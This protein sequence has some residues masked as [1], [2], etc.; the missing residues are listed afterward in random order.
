MLNP[1]QS[2]NQFSSAEKVFLQTFADL[3]V[4]WGDVFFVGSDLQVHRLAAGTSGLF[5]QTKGAGADP[6]WAA[7][8]SGGSPLTTKGDLFGYD[9]SANRIPVGSNG[10]VLTAD[11]SQALGVKWAT[12]TGTGTVTSVTSA[13]ANATVANTTTTPVITIVSAPKWATARNLAGNSTDGSANVTFANKFIVQGT[14]DTGLSAAQFLGALTTGIV[15][16][17]TTTGVLSIAV[18]ADFPT[19]NQNTTGNAAT[20]TT[21]A[22]LTGA[23][24]SVGNATSLG[25]FSSAALAAALTDETGSGVAVFGSSPTIDSINLTGTSVWNGS[26]SGATTLRASAIAGSTALVLPAAND[27]LVGRATTDTLTNKTI[28]GA[29]NT[30]TVRLASDVTGNLPVTNLNSGTSASSTT[31]WRGDGTWATPSGSAS[32]LT[33]K[34]DLYG[35]STVNARLPV[36]TDTFVLT[37]DSTQTLGVKW[38]AATGSSATPFAETPSGLVNS[39]NTTYTLANMPS[40]VVGVIVTLD[41]VVQRNGSGLDYTVSGTTITFVAAPATGSEIFAYY[42]TLTGAGSGTVTSVA[43]ADG[44]ITVTN[45]TST[46]DLAVVKAPKLTTARNIAGNS[47]DGSANTTFANKFIVQGTADSGLTGAQFL[48]ALSTG[49]VKNTTTTGVLSIATAGTDYEVPLTFSTGLTRSTNTITVNVSQNITTLSNLTSN[50]IVTTSG[51][52]GTLSVT[53]T[54]GSG[55][56]VLATSPTLTTAVLGSSTATTQSPSDNSTKVA[57]TAYVDAAVLGQNF[58]EAALVA[59]TANLVGVYV[60]GVFTYTATGVNTIDGVTL[61]LGNRVLVKNQTTTFQNGIYV[62]T[63]AGA[64]GVAGVLTR[65]SDANSSGEFK[66]GD[67]IFV[68][69]GTANA[70]TTWAYTGVDSP[71]IG[72]DAITYAQSAGQGTVT[73]GN[74]IAVTGLSVAIDTSITVDK[75]TTQTLTNKTLTSPVLTTPTLGTPASGTL[76]NTTGFPVANLAGAGTGVLTFLATPSSSNLASALTDKT[77]TGVNVFATSP[78]LVTPTLGVATATRLGVGVAADASRLLLVQGDVSGG[79]ATINRTNSATNAAVG[80]VIIKATST[81]TMTDGFGAAFQFAIQDTGVAETLIAN[82]QGVK[83]GTTGG[84]LVFSTNT[85]AGVITA[86]A[87]IDNTQTLTLLN[88]LPVNSGGSGAATLTGILKGNGTSA[89]TAVT[90]PSGAI[91]GISDTQTLTNKRITKR[92]LALS[93]GSATPAINTDSYDVVNITAQSAAITS[94]TSSL[95]GTPVDGDTIR[96]SITDNGTARAITWGT[97]FEASTVA[98]PTTTVISTRLDVGFFWNAATSKW[99][100]VASA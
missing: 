60:S 40:S 70:S 87:Q 73:A 96:I 10:S 9:T 98:L 44:S 83:Q 86:A 74:G 88:A 47:F 22:N 37:A 76:T 92:V 100:C 2:N 52:A 33:T 99:R 54:T 7:G 49:I 21:N 95:T 18:A 20:V 51:S 35:F 23:I 71:T 1:F 11:S 43:S 32:P 30:L 94:F 91:V 63:T 65:A 4:V 68:T 93:A 69:S 59:T 38:A 13:D 56:V 42:N 75:T 53:A 27:T 80:T 19:L 36:G 5:L 64:L 28:N 17:T 82:I 25:S 41:G 45:P 66:T 46:V 67:S 90:A 85:S 34:G 61:A 81:G 24:T 89:F 8:G 3:P 6:A 55:N 16:N 84:T 14:T 57:T 79:V 50:G 97:S 12:V 29:S 15:K 72:T 26:T 78:T 39:S 77:G 58:K 48:G 62:V 31:F